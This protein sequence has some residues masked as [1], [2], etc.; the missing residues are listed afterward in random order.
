M[1]DTSG[2]TVRVAAIQ[3]RGTKDAEQN[4]RD[5]E[6]LIREAASDGAVYV[7]TPEI[8]N[9]VDRDG[10]RMRAA[11]RTEADDPVLARLRE[12]A[13]EL[14][15]HL[16]VGSL[17]LADGDAAVNRGF[18]IGPDGSI[19]AR[20]DKIHMFDVD[21]PDGESWRESRTYRP[22]ER[23]VAVQLPFAGLGMT[24]CYDLRFPALYRALAEAG[25]DILTVPACFTKQTGEAHWHVLTRARAI[26]TG[27]FVIAATQ[28]GHHEDGR[29]TYGHAIIIDPWGKVI[30]EGG[31]DPCVVAADIELGKV[32]SAR[33][34]V[35]ALANARPF[36]EP[37]PLAGE[38]VGA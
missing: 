4:A 27:S 5:A 30:A 23:A 36:A 13:R 18:L 34:R 28:G 24:I 3:M 8:T 15:I 2:D 7:Q 19:L 29:D 17:A 22:G 10:K 37:V 11:M 38:D 31:T 25:A 6:R 33:R 16:H 20:Y 21:L 12:L 1:S 32:A 14:E 9:L 26:E 35:P